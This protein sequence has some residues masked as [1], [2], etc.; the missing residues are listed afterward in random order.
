MKTLS[1]DIAQYHLE[2]IL[3]WSRDVGR[4][5]AMLR[6]VARRRATGCLLFV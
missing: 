5:G 4:C 1:R 6:D 2:T 3:L